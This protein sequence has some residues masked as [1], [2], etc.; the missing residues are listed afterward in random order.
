M[1][2]VKLSLVG[3]FLI[4]SVFFGVICFGCTA[5]AS[6]RKAQ[7]LRG[8]TRRLASANDIHASQMLKTGELGAEK[9]GMQINRRDT[10]D[11]KSHQRV[12]ID[13]AVPGD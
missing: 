9:E 5:S 4:S 10:A 8:G 13:H 12:S 6:R 1:V 2:R 11:R 3:L 7:L